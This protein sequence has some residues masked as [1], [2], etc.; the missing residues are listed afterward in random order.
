MQ[1]IKIAHLYYDLLNL[2]GE[3]GN[4]RALKKFI[5]MQDVKCEIHFLSIGDTINFNDYD[6]FYMGM[7]TENSLLLVLKDIQK[8]KEDIK[9]AIDNGKFFLVTGNSIE[10]FGEYLIDL[11]NKKY[12]CLN[13][14][15]Y[16]TE[17]KDFRI[18]GSVTASSKL[19]KN[20]IIGFQNRCGQIYDIDKPLLK[21]KDGTGMNLKNNFEGIQYK[22]FYGTY[23]LGPLL[24]RNPYLTNHIIKNLIHAKNKKYKFKI[25]NRIPEIKAY[26]T[27][28]ENFDIKNS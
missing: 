1:K 2:Y 7:G 21:I 26:N 6:M 22:N 15:G 9:D 12:D 3:N 25:Y 10:L 28:L 13:T 8:Y 27:Y 20:Y 14:F 19:F 5:E 11:N 24:I 18:V 23:L 17:W 4:I 16:H